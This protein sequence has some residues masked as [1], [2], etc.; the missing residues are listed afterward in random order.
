MIDF[1]EDFLREVAS[2]AVAFEPNYSY[3][4]DLDSYARNW[5]T[6]AERQA[7]SAW[8]RMCT[9]CTTDPHTLNS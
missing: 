4:T 2:V 5:R 3:G 6:G 1:R 8:F 9:S 7:I